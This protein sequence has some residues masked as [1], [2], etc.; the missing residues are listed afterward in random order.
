[1][2]FRHKDMKTGN[3]NSYLFVDDIMRTDQ[4]PIPKEFL[5][6]IPPPKGKVRHGTFGTFN[7]RDFEKVAKINYEERKAK[8]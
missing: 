4:N 3:K 8:I 5:E 2:T 6:R 7:A 1:M